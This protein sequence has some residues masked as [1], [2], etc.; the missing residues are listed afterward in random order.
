MSFETNWMANYYT[1]SKAC[2]CLTYASEYGG[3]CPNGE[4][5]HATAQVWRAENA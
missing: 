2:Y 5:Y 1:D 3:D 4:S